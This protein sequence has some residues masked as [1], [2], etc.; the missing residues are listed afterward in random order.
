MVDKIFK[1]MVVSEQNGEFVREIKERS[2]DDLPNG[3]I[4][5]NVKYSALNYKDALSATGNSGITRKYPHTPGIDAA[6]VVAASNNNLFNKGDEV[7]VTSYDLGMNTSG[8]FGQYIRV[9]AE[10]AVKLPNGLTLKESMTFGTAGLTAALSLYRMES[11]GLIPTQDEL[12]VTGSTGGVGSMAVAVLSRVGYHVVAATGKPDKEAYLKKLGAQSIIHRQEIN[13]TSGKPLLNGRWG[14]VVDTAGGNTL[15]TAIK[16]TKQWGIIAACG[17]T[18]S[19]EFKTTVF[20]FILR[21][22]NLIGIN[23]E[24]CPMQTRA[25]LWK[26]MASAWKIPNLDAISVECSLEET[27]SKI[28]EILNGRITGRVVVD[29]DKT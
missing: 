22:V 25:D 23:T 3:D 1:A 2:I 14:A 16:S 19:I 11:L 9:P 8:G 7:I 20:P 18:H 15:A 10:W 29:L 26:M 4:L 21:G 27:C 12:L 28:D 17:L 6:G 5:V 24:Q 13:D